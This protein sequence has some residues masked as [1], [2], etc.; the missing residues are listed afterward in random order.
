[1]ANKEAG[2]YLHV[3][4]GTQQVFY[5]GYTGDIDGKRPYSKGNRNNHWK[6]TFK[7]YGRDVVLFSRGSAEAM[8]DLEIELIASIGVGN[9]CNMSTGGEASSQGISR[10]YFEKSVM[11][12]TK[13]MEFVGEYKSLSEA[14]E[15]TGI[16]ISGISRVV[17]GERV[18]SGGFIWKFKN[19]R[20]EQ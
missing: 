9:L 18:T 7:K 16:H 5:V 8:L 19:N 6:N 11:Q 2:V 15:H 20:D 3:R 1:M 13:K 12:Y 4:P 17:R 14:S 10:S